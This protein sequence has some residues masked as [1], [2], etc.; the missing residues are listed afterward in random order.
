MS[1]M[2]WIAMAVLAAHLAAQT[3]APP[4]SMDIRVV[5]VAD[6]PGQSYA[7]FVPST[8]T[9][10]RAWPIL[11]CLDPGARGRTAVEAFTA[12][13]EKAGFLV[14]GSNNSRNGPIAVSVEAIRLMLQHTRQTYS[15]DD[16]RVYVAGLSGGA[17]LALGWASQNDN[18]A[19]V[20]ASSAGFGTSLPKQ[21]SFHIFLTTGVDDFNH[22][23]LYH[24]SRELARRNVPHRYVEFVGGHEWLPPA[25]ADEAFAYFAGTVPPQAAPA[26]KAVEHLASQYE[27]VTAQVQS[28]NL[29]LL[30]Q[31][32]KD[33]ARA[34]D[35]GERR[36]AR[37]VIGGIFVESMERIRDLMTQKKYDEAARAA[38]VAVTARSD[39]ANAWY[40]LAVAQAG[41]GYT[42][43]AL[44]AMEQA[45]ANGF[46]N[47]ALAEQEPLLAKVR[48][49]PR[50]PK[51]K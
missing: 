28:G 16:S 51:P 35:S 8:Y 3:A 25:L 2:K 37:R 11:Y 32:R 12:A 44:E 9:A 26:S 48:R 30:K 34:E 7:M 43:R 10:A 42:K 38:E 36:V 14:A 45:V 6:H 18:I 27:A 31:M 33:A 46:S 4:A 20:V 1:T 17:R 41:A 40:T 15:I 5:D 21:I 23:E 50:Y 19:G 49:D 39:S 47:W 24:L 13:A 29:A 22:D